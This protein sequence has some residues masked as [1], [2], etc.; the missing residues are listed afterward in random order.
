MVM[1]FIIILMFIL[2]VNAAVAG[3]TSLACLD[4]LTTD[5]QYLKELVDNKFDF[6]KLKTSRIFVPTDHWAARSGRHLLR[7]TDLKMGIHFNAI[8]TPA[9]LVDCLLANFESCVYCLHP[10]TNNMIDPELL[11]TSWDVMESRK[12][13]QSEANIR[14]ST[15]D[16]IIKGIARATGTVVA[17]EASIK[18]SDS[19]TANPTAAGSSNIDTPNQQKQLSNKIIPDYTFYSLENISGS[20]LTSVCALVEVKRKA[21][22]NDDAVCQTIGY[23]IARKQSKQRSTNNGQSSVLNANNGFILYYYPRFLPI[24]TI[25]NSILRG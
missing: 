12:L 7:A 2:L 8:D 1:S 6:L 9:L 5:A 10:T 22:F 19:L 13:A 21:C 20:E 23:Y 16:P 11:R 4:C 17:L 3:M 24:P 18:G 25:G 14:F 15:I